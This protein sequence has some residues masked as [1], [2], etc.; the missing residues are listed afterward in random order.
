MSKREARSIAP[1]GVD[2]EAP[3]AKR[4]KEAPAATSTSTDGKEVAA[5]TQAQGN[6]EGTSKA[7]E[8]SEEIKRKGMQLWNAMKDAVHE[9]VHIA[10]NFMRLPSGRQYPDYYQL[11][12]HPIALEDIRLK[13]R[14]GQYT[15]MADLKLDFERCFRNAKRY[16]MKESSIW[17]EAKFL[18]KY[19][20]KEYA[21]VTGIK[22]EESDDGEG[23][24][25]G[26][27]A[28]HRCLKATLQ[29]IVDMRSPNGRSLST[30]FM[31]LPS[32]VL[33]PY[34]YEQIKK[35][36][37]LDKIFKKLKRKAY[38]N[39]TDFADDVELVFQ[40]ALQ[41]NSDGSPIYEDARNLR[42][43]FRKLMA[44]LPEQFAAPAYVNAGDHPTK[45][46][47]KMP[48]APTQPVAAP[49][50]TLPSSNTI[51]VSRTQTRRPP[52]NTD[53]ATS[54][55]PSGAS[56]LPLTSDKSAATT[57]AVPTIP[58]PKPA[59]AQASSS[60]SN[61]AAPTA[62]S[63]AAKERRRERAKLNAIRREYIAAGFSSI[64]IVPDDVDG[65]LGEPLAVPRR[66]GQASPSPDPVPMSPPTAGSAGPPSAPMFTFTLK[67]AIVTTMP[68]RR[69][70]VLHQ[71]D[72]T[73]TWTM[74]LGGSETSVI[75]SNIT[76][77][78]LLE[79]DED[80]GAEEEAEAQADGEDGA[81]PA[82]GKKRARFARTRAKAS[83]TAKK[84]KGKAPEMQVKLDGAVMAFRTGM[85][86]SEWEVPLPPGV[87]VLEF[88]EKGGMVWR[89]YM[90]RSAF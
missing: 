67:H 45:I 57:S 32:P 19:L 30:E 38:A 59:N 5:G 82:K 4:R 27:K 6:N 61:A 8:D 88:G 2:I 58:D 24:V 65:N 48:S 79:H 72:G 83:E 28:L 44:D 40:N 77:I 33:W 46:K 70:L 74:R 56:H 18:H 13:L 68:L 50:P 12:K 60:S 63:S 21:R 81:S 75:L 76:F 34:Y 78:G 31:Q 51:A 37:S 20:G 86:G 71:E 73:R 35:P 43:T 1:A 39:S 53:E 42:D 69:R 41:F 7:V 54:A 64:R 84:A 87:S 22:E 62:S 89:V 16:N 3:R 9:G 52:R 25:D 15:S 55:A 49:A 14:K 90:D 10:R 11:I 85:E 80:S 23:D 66:P 17:Q 47:L 26:K 29:R 36:L